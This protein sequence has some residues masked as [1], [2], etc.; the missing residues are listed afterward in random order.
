MIGF[1]YTCLSLTVSVRTTHWISLNFRYPRRFLRRIPFSLI[2]ILL[3]ILSLFIFM[4]ESLR[5]GNWSVP[6][7]FAWGKAEIKLLHQCKCI[8]VRFTRLSNLS[9][10][11]IFE[12]FH[13]YDR[14]IPQSSMWENHFSNQNWNVCLRIFV[15]VPLSLL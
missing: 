8:N 10:N 4:K 9:T 11:Y 13:Y 5:Y 3:M 1:S 6:L 14:F 15:K 2:E 12:D 7:C